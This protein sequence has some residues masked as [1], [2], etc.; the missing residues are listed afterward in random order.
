VKKITSD[1][2]YT[3]SGQ[4][5]KNHVLIVNDDGVILNIDSIDKH[6]NG[7][8]LTLTGA[9][10]PGFVNTHTHTELS[11]LKNKIAKGG[12]LSRFIVDLLSVR[13]AGKDEIQQAIE[14]ADR[15]MWNKGIVAVGDIANTADALTIKQKSGI[16][17]H[18]FIE[19]LGYKEE[20]SNE[21]FNE[22]VALLQQHK[23]A[24]LSASIAPH[25]PY[26]LSRNLWEH[27]SLYISLTSE[28]TSIHMAESNEELTYV[29]DGSGSMKKILEYLKYPEETFTPF[30]LRSIQ[31]VWPYMEHAAQT[32]MVHN[33][34]LAQVDFDFLEG[35]LKKIWF[36]TCPSANIYIEKLL[37][38][39][40]L[41]MSNTNRIC[42][43][44]DSLASNSQLS[45][46]EELKTI[47]N[48][49]PEI[50]IHDLLCWATLNGAK[51]LRMNNEFGSIEVNKKPGLVHLE[52]NPGN[53]NIWEANV[54]RII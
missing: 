22:S 39:Y 28:V 29:Y 9:I 51:A 8:V 2:I 12:G 26:S 47:H 36:C 30:G 4:V 43:G 50:E 15:E 41:W 27:I 3:V 24:G 14:D 37:P 53:Q 13:N 38:D 21:I 17:Y 42:V 35:V 45:I 31:S 46:W 54:R 18:T 25:A 1:F 19:T 52:Y 44:T 34:F 32:I 20:K 16:R 5:L 23:Q 10:V 49:F 7:D 11:F 33:T 48:N 6:T 40:K